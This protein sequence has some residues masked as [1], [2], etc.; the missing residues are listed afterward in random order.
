MSEYTE[1]IDAIGKVA[2]NPLKS[3]EE[4]IEDSCKLFNELN[5]M[6]ESLKAERK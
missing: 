4:C 1:A 2:F 6:I 3:V 5:K